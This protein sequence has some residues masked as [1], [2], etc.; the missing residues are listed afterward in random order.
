M[1]SV[2]S[3]Y[4]IL[5]DFD[6]LMWYPPLF[7]TVRVLCFFHLIISISWK[8]TS[9]LC[10]SYPSSNFYLPLLASIDN[11]CQHPTL[12]R[13][14]QSS[15]FSKSI[16]SFCIYQ[17]TLYYEESFSF[18]LFIYCL[19]AQK[20]GFLFYSQ[21]YNLLLWVLV[22]LMLTFSKIWPVETSVQLQC[23]F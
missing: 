21:S 16:I 11:F 3:Q 23:F 12:I 5:V 18:S 2:C 10:I 22:I 13:W 19:S 6:H 15:D 9:R 8:N 1:Q 7:A 20:H 4:H 14:L 17:M